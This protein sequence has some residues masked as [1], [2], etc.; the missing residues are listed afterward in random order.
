MLLAQRYELF[1]VRK[2]DFSPPITKVS[3][4]FAEM[5]NKKASVYHTPT[6]RILVSE[7]GLLD[8][9]SDHHD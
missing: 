1:Y 6:G 5:S 4:D 9:S 2:L 8:K 3:N 7:F